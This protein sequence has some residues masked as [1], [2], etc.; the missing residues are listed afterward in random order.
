[1]NLSV[2]TCVKND[3]EGLAA[4]L[5]SIFAQEHHTQTIVIDAGKGTDIQSVLE[6]YGPKI[7]LVEHNIDKGISHA[8]NVG[9]KKCTGDLIAILNAGDQWLPETTSLVNEQFSSGHLYV[10]HGPVIFQPL[11]GNRYT[12]QPCINKMKERMYVFHP[13]LFIPRNIYA[14]IGGYDESYELAMDSEWCHRAI[15]QGVEFR[16]IR[17]PLAV[18]QLGGRSDA[19]Y[20]RALLEYRRSLISNRLIGWLPATFYF[21]YFAIGKTLLKIVSNIRNSF[22][23]HTIRS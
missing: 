19:H 11:K 17:Q 3:A 15:M 14:Q 12:I 4:T 1:M 20:I 21:V 7:D 2:I 22:V 6:Y 18:M 10:I 16:S 23:P 5:E 13:T 8:F 9:L